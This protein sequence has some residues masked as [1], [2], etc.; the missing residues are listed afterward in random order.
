M[1]AGV[2]GF[3]ATSGAIL[4]RDRAGVRRKVL[5]LASSMA[6]PAGLSDIIRRGSVEK[7][8]SASAAATNG[9]EVLSLVEPI[10]VGERLHSG[11]S[12]PLLLGLS[13][14]R[15]ASSSTPAGS[16]GPT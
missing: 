14:Y 4:A 2:V 3:V 9:K 10:W 7:L 15:R 6:A 16:A 8:K 11:L 13:V 1:G 5:V 12:Q